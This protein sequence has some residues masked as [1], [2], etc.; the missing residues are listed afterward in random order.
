[1]KNKKICFFI[2][3]VISLPTNDVFTYG[4][5]RSVFSTEERK[6][7]TIRTINSIYHY[8]PNATI[9]FVEGGNEMQEDI[10]E[11]VSLYYWVGRKKIIRNAVC[12]KSKAWGEAII[13]L[14][15]IYLWFK[16]D[17]VFKISGRYWLNGNIDYEKVFMDNNLHITGLDIYNDHTQISTRLLGIPKSCYLY[18]LKALIRRI[19]RLPN[20]N[21]VYEAY[22][23][24]GIKDENI[25]FVSTIGISGY[26]GV[27]NLYIEE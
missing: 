17:Y 8:F 27:E 1:M 11:L 5:I 7:Q 20:K 3:S 13:T 12:N 25:N 26:T 2:T 19:W 24:R 10:K 6:K 23:K 9:I 4:T 14:S 15:K 21:V 16:Y 22:L 18:I